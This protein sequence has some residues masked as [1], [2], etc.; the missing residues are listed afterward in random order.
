VPTKKILWIEDDAFLLGGLVRPLEKDGYQ[1]VVARNEKEALKALE[2]EEFDLILFDIIIPS[3]S[4]EDYVEYVGLRLADEIV[5]KR[6][7]R[8]PI[9]AISVVSRPDIL[10]NFYKLGFKKIFSKGHVLPSELKEEVNKILNIRKEIS[11]AS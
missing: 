11:K 10:D 3:G 1:I 7:I 9:I 4:D 8:T 5:T 6:N 2:N